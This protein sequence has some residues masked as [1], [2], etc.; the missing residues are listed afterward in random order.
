LRNIWAMKTQRA[1]PPDLDPDHLDFI[2]YMAQVIAVTGKS[3]TQ[4]AVDAGLPPS[5]VN[6]PYNQPAKYR[7]VPKRSTIRAIAR[8]TGIPYETLPDIANAVRVGGFEAVGILG[9][10][11][12]IDVRGGVYV[13]VADTT[14]DRLFKPGSRLFC[15]PLGTKRPLRQSG[16]CLV[17]HFHTSRAAGDVFEY[18]ILQCFQ[19]GPACDIN[20][21]APTSD[22][23]HQLAITLERL[24][25][26]IGGFADAGA[27]MAVAKQGIDYAPRDADKAEIIG[28]VI[29]AIPPNNMHLVKAAE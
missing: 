5:T 14:C 25:P 1:V 22:H 19:S 3:P 17:A 9:P 21:I 27:P 4:I 29:Q 15:A 6:R 24:A 2:R 28:I 7:H 13:D 12:R 20:L 10:A 18:R 23:R 26:T 8:A 16:A 11:D